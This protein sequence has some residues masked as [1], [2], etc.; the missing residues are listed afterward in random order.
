[1]CKYFLKGQ[2][3]ADFTRSTFIN[4]ILQ[5]VKAKRKTLILLVLILSSSGIQSGAP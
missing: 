1:M 4:L 2:P 5:K 3:G